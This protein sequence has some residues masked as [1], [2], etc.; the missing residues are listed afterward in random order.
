MRVQIIPLVGCNFKITHKVI[1]L[2]TVFM[3]YDGAVTCIKKRC[4]NKLMYSFLYGFTVF[5]QSSI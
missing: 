1:Q 5:G 2:I 3:V 4:T